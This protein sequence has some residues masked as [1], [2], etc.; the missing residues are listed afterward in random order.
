M[1]A[2]DSVMIG[3]V[4]F[5][6]LYHHDGRFVRGGGLFAFA[7]RDPDGGRTIFCLELAQDIS[8]QA[9][10]GHAAWA[11]AVSNGMNELLVHLAGSQQTPGELEQGA[12]SP[13]ALRP[14]R[15]QRRGARSAW[16]SSSGRRPRRLTWASRPADHRLTSPR[17]SAAAAG[18]DRSRPLCW[19]ESLRGTRRASGP[20][21]AAA[22]WRPRPS[23]RRSPP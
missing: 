18:A 21:R 8:R 4:Q 2:D 7:R 19:R 11:H 13:P 20:G 6:S 10:C 16:R 15:R 22:R 3:G 1:T 9:D 12:S 5:M 23:P 14:V 17:P